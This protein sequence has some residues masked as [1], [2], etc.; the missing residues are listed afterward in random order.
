MINNQRDTSFDLI[1]LPLKATSTPFLHRF[2]DPLPR[3]ITG[4]L[5]LK[6]SRIFHSMLLCFLKPVV[7]QIIKFNGLFSS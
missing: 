2:S 7:S 3:S 1:N 6:V 5:E 4:G